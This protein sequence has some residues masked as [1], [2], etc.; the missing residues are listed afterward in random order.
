MILVPPFRM[1]VDQFH[2]G[3][4]RPERPDGVQLLEHLADLLLGVPLLPVPGQDKVIDQRLPD[5]I[6]FPALPVL[7]PQ[8]VHELV[9]YRIRRYVGELT[10]EQELPG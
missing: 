8:I 5:G 6:V 9:Y 7:M 10:H 2:A 3:V 4:N 1:A